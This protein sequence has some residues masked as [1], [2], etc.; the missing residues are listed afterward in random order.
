MV[1]YRAELMIARGGHTGLP[2]SVPSRVSRRRAAHVCALDR[3]L[4]C[5]SSGYL[6]DGCSCRSSI[7]ASVVMAAWSTE[8]ERDGAHGDRLFRF[9]WRGDVWLA[10]GL[11]SGGVR[12]VYCP[13]HRA[14]RDDRSFLYESGESRPEQELALSA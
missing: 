11:E 3:P 9:A 14:E 2:P 8:L 12:G 10:Y 4:R 7:P 13:S 6:S 5:V 1:G